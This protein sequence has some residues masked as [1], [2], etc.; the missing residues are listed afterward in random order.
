[1]KGFFSGKRPLWQAFWG[2]F[3]G[4]YVIIFIINGSITALLVDSVNLKLITVIIALIT[5]VFLVVS[6]I[7]VWRCSTNVSWKAWVWVSRA[8]I[9]LAII[10]AIYSTYYTWYTLISEIDKISK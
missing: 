6:G 3:I 4:G 5:L 7:V 8:V 2:I 1:M 9:L 10:R